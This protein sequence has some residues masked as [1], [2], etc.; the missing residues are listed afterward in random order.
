MEPT[1]PAQGIMTTGVYDDARSFRVACDCHDNEH[2]VDVWI[3]VETEKEV[4]EITVTFY[5]E[6]DT[7]WWEQGFN[8]FREAWNILVHGRSRFSGALIMQAEAADNLCNAIQTSI[9]RLQQKNK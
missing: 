9:Q 2:D 3:E 4:P 7:P 6:L 5:R 1:L 8:R